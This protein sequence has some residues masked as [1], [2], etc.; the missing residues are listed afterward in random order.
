MT[1]VLTDKVK[2]DYVNAHVDYP[3]IWENGLEAYPFARTRIVPIIY[4]IPDGAK[5]L[6][7]GCNSG[8]FIKYLKEKK[9]C[10]VYGVDI[11]QKVVDICKSK[12]LDAQVVDA[13]NLP[14][15]D[16]TFDVVT[17][18]EVLEHFHEPV[19]YLKEIRRVLKPTGY[20]LGT[21][22]HAN[23]ERYIWDDKRLHQQYYT[24]KGLR[25]DLDQAFEVTHLQIL[26]GAQFNLG[27]INSFVANLPCEILFK[28]G[29]KDIAPWEEQMKKGT[30]LRVWMGWTQLSGDVYY[31][32]R[33]YADKM[34]DIGLDIAYEHF[35]YDGMEQQKDWQR[36]IRNKIVL[37]ELD[38]L[39][40][41]ADLSIWQLVGNRDCLAF[42]RCAK[43]VVKKPI[44]TEI[45]DWIFDLP[46]YNIAANPYKPNSEPEWVCAQQLKLSD[47]FIASTNFIKDKLIES[48]PDRPV[49]VIP[50]SIDFNIWDNLKPTQRDEVKKADGKIRIGYTGCGN[51]DGD[52][53][54][55]KRP[56]LK[57]LE[58]FPNLEFVSSHVFPSWKDFPEDRFINS[59]RWVTINHYPNEVAGWYMDIGIAPLRDNNFNRA[60][61]NLRWLEFSALHLPTVASRVRP[62]KESIREGVD[63]ILCS[64]E[65][66]WYEA[67]KILIVDVQKR[68]ALGETAYARVKKDFNM[69]TVAKQY[70]ETLER[71]KAWNDQI[72][73][74]KLAAS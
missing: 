63:G 64:S 28:S 36:R 55:V 13:D 66:E 46:A 70:A 38:K 69:D 58:E 42:L 67:L 49:Y 21:C 29:S 62:F 2:E 57:L 48:F 60:K 6:D 11:S 30:S 54:I 74:Q 52:M 20:L 3:D 4:E 7:V 14:F 18:M 71:I 61:S 25:A 22:P 37:N 47:A 65:L 1:S 72:L 26:S 35:E 16:A 53:D 56:I 50:N 23:L 39:L 34:R 10:D 8:E 5:V 9:G 32:M 19:K 59:N 51:H 27:F 15:S 73:T 17:L 24:E 41:V 45:D 12:G 33:G 68:K 43:D 31:R 44:I 40:K